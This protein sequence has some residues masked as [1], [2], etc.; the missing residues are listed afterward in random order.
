MYE[1]PT[2]L[3]VLD[4]RRGHAHRAGLSRGQRERGCADITAIIHRLP[5]SDFNSTI[6]Y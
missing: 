6:H 5:T 2:T 1:H 4:D 3:V